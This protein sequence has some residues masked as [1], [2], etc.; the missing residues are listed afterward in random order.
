MGCLL[1][2]VALWMFGYGL[3]EHDWRILLASAAI[4]LIWPLISDGVGGVAG[5]RR[6]RQLLDYLWDDD[7]LSG[8]A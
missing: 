8:S 4:A 3:W 7:D 2:G 6:H 5:K 1:A